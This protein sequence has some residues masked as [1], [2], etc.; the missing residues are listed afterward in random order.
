MAV[1]AALIAQDW[2]GTLPAWL[3]VCLVILGGF[4]FVK[5][6]GG[7]ALNTLQIANQVLEKRVHSLEDQGKEDAKLIAELKART[8]VSVQIQPLVK[9]TGEHETRDQERFE[10]TIVVLDRIS[11]NLD[12]ISD[13]LAK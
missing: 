13:K 9:W 11:S 4:F 1:L 2:I 3:T 7:T 5:G 6:A 8:D 12:Q 10:K